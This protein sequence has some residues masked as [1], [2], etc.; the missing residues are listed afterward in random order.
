MKIMVNRRPIQGPWGGG[1]LFVRAICNRIVQKGHSLVHNLEK[2][3]DAIII[4]DPRNEGGYDSIRDIIVFA[5]QNKVATLLRVN[6]CDARK[7][8]NDID[9]YLQQVSNFVNK[10]VFVS[11]WMKDYHI[12]KGWKCADNSVIFNGVNREIFRPLPRLRNGKINLVTH[13]WSNNRMKGFD[14]YDAID[15]L[16][17]RDSRY[18]FT[19]IGRDR[20]TFKNT[21]VIPPLF[22]KELGDVLGIFD[23]YISAS[24]ADP[25]PNHVIE[26]IACGIP[27]FSISGGGGSCEFTGKNWVYDGVD[28]L[29]RMIDSPKMNLDPFEEWSTCADKFLELIS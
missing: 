29:M 19:Y 23:I 7:G 9:E 16:V 15:D 27:T 28:D 1:N 20:G 13:H 8:T 14:V 10:T 6:E 5:N 21:R 24:I 18:T 17:G 22:G 2:G 12:G 4:V 3:I 11:S 26:S 25:G